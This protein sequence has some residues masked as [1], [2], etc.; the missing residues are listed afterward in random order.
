MI[1]HEVYGDYYNAVALIIR[2]AIDGN[3][4]NK[5]IYEIAEKKAF[6]ESIM[7]IPNAILTS[8]WPL[9]DSEFKTPIINNPTMPITDI[10]KMWLKA[11][12]LDK[13]ISLFDP[14]LDGLEDVEPLFDEDTFVYY[15]QYLD[16][17]PFDNLNYRKCFRHILIGL[18]QKHMLTV[19]FNGKKGKHRQLVIPRKLE[20]S[21]KDDKF[22]LICENKS[23]YTYY[24]NVAKIKTCELAE[25]FD[26]DN[27]QPLRVNKHEAILIITD[28]RGAMERAMLQ[29]S[30]LEKE[31]VRIDEAHYR[32]RLVYHE[33]DE[34]EILIRILAFGPLVKV[35]EPLSFRKL[36]RERIIN[37]K[38]LG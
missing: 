33:A 25:N 8:R 17:D 10:Q 2:E 34:T 6:G 26:E 14:C 37:Q 11:I 18:K 38:V 28:E 15:D 30:D 29:F 3:L 31:T 13:R 32:M 36:I 35:I 23:G 5:K 27:L 9:L 7:T 4:D 20:Y 22:R 16:G 1:F 24:I 21:A 12:L 19:E